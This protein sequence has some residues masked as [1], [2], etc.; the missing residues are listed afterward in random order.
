MPGIGYDVVALGEQP[1]QRDL[2]R[3]G[4][5]LGCDRLQPLDEDVVRGPMVLLDP[6]IVVTE[7]RLVE[8]RRIL[9][10]PREKPAAE[11][12]VRDE[13]DAERSADRQDRLL[14]T[15]LVERVLGLHGRDRMHSVSP[16]ER[17]GQNLR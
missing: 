1:R 3:C 16:R 11:R 15:P 12:A 8:L 4:C 5:Q 10:A 17:L 9:E 7:V 13:P 6:R 14:D 2:G